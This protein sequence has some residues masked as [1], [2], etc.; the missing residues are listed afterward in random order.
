MLQLPARIHYV[1]MTSGMD[2]NV[3]VSCMLTAVVMSQ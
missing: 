3:R 2:V 1:A